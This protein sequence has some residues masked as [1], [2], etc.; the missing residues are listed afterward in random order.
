MPGRQRKQQRPPSDSDSGPV[1]GSAELLE[2][3]EETQEADAASDG[4]EARETAGALFT[5]GC[6]FFM[7]TFRCWRPAV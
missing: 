1:N 2:E 6:F 3:D 7:R 5:T 4:E